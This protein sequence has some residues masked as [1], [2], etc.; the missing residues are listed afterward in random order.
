MALTQMRLHLHEV[1]LAERLLQRLK[2]SNDKPAV[3]ALL[4][5]TQDH[6]SSTDA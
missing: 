2:N 1:A 6:F 5:A 3:F 4:C